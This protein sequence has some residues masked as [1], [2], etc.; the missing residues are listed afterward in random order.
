MAG[1]DKPINE[2]KTKDANDL[3]LED[4]LIGHDDGQPAAFRTPVEAMVAKA[5]G[6]VG[7]LPILT[8]EHMQQDDAVLLHRPGDEQPSKQAT[9]GSLATLLLGEWPLDTPLIESGQFEPTLQG[10]TQNPTSVTYD[11]RVGTWYRIGQLVFVQGIMGTTARSG[12]EGSVRIGGLPYP[13]SG[14]AGA[15]MA[16]CSVELQNIT[17]PSSTGFI[18]GVFVTNSTTI[19]MNASRDGTAIVSV[20]MS[21]W[22]TFGRVRFGGVY[23]ASL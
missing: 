18:V 3:A 2:L 20:G 19:Q 5:L 23:V 12:G 17:F 8:S 1:A 21:N 11:A 4:F 9:L 16:T 15:T 22:S 6:G 13:V 7:D 10:T 14:V